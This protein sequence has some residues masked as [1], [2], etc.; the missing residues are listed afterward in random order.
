MKLS[1]SPKQ[2]PELT[3]FE[4]RVLKRMFGPKEV[5][6]DWR[7][8]NEELCNIYSSQ[9]GECSVHGRCEKLIQNF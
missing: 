4:N 6:G 9:S 5:T 8:Y 7:V 2:N 3:L 1:L